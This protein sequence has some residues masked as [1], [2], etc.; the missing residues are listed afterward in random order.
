[1]V[2]KQPT[3]KGD[4]DKFFIC[5]S[6]LRRVDGVEKLCMNDVNMIVM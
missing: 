1:M 3:V 4:I 6:T 5:S 2:N